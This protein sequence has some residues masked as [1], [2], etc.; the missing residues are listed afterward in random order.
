[1]QLFEIHFS[2][3][4]LFLFLFSF[5]SISFRNRTIEGV[6]LGRE[7]NRPTVRASMRIDRMKSRL[8][9]CRIGGRHVCPY[10][11]LRVEGIAITS[12]LSSIVHNDGIVPDLREKLSRCR[13]PEI[14]SNIGR[15]NIL[16]TRRRDKRLNL[17]YII[18]LA[19]ARLIH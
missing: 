17:E 11:R 8:I 2:A 19:S 13:E 12:F 10:S 6:R 18:L 14:E 1:M 16:I 15:S 4:F 7:H 9:V 3:S 5:S